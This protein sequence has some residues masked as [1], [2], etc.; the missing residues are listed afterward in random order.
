VSIKGPRIP[1]SNTVGDFLVHGLSA[2]PFMNSQNF[3]GFQKR[4]EAI[5]GKNGRLTAAATNRISQI[6]TLENWLLIPKNREASFFFYLPVSLRI[7]FVFSFLFL[8]PET[9]VISVNILLMQ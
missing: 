4:V 3:H 9:S 8:C 6:F 5:N 7:K 1:Y 2:C